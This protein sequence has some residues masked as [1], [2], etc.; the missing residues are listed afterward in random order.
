MKHP[1]KAMPWLTKHPSTT[2]MLQPTKRSRT[3]VHVGAVG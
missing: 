1:T 2:R 3:P